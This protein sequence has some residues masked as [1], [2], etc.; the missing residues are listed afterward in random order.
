MKRRDLTAGVVFRYTNGPE[1]DALFVD[2]IHPATPAGMVVPTD[3]SITSE[4]DPDF[5]PDAPVTIIWKPPT[6]K[7]QAEDPKALQPKK[8][9][10]HY[11][12]AAL[13]KECSDALEEGR[14][15][16]GTAKWR[17]TKT[18]S[19]TYLGGALRHIFA[20]IEGEDID[21]DSITGKTHLA[22]AIASLAIL[23]DCIAAGTIVDNRPPKGPGAAL[24]RAVKK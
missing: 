15:K 2:E 24:M 13:L 19:M 8:P 14:I 22:G 17:E 9:A 4:D 5:G 16:Y 10:I 21:P 3:V 6:S 11:V 18:E 12:P 20:Y 23:V 7:Q 1:N